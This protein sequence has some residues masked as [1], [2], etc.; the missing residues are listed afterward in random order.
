MDTA[1]RHDDLA[2]EKFLL[3]RADPDPHAGDAPAVEHEPGHECITGNAEIAA[4]PHIGIEI[5]DRC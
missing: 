4:A 5:A 1:Q 2:G 3:L